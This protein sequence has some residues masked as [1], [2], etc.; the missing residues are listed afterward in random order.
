[1]PGADPGD[2]ASSVASEA[3]DHAGK[4][5]G[6]GVGLGDLVDH[7]SHALHCFGCADERTTLRTLDLDA[8]LLP[9]ALIMLGYAA[10]TAHAPDIGGRT[11]SHDL[12]DV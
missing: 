10:T 7:R 1:M 4:A 5:P 6:D 9:Q 8:A 3:H 2:V 12:R 11:G